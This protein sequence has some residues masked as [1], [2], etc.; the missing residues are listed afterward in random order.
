M[1]YTMFTLWP[2]KLVVV[3]S[4]AVPVPSVFNVILNGIPTEQYVTSH[5]SFVRR[6]RTDG[7]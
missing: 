7:E 1:F 2:C 3:S 4:E 6:L 5:F